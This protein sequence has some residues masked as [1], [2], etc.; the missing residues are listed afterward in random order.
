MKIKSKLLAG[1]TGVVLFIMICSTAAVYMLL[2]KQNHAVVQRNLEKTI[3]L[4]KDDLG[5]RQAKQIK[6]TSQLVTANKVGENIKFISDFAGQIDITRDGYVKTTGALAQLLS[7]SELWQA[8]VYDQKGMIIA[9]AQ[10]MT[11]NTLTVV[12][13]YGEGLLTFEHARLN[14]GDP[15]NEAKWQQSATSPLSVI[16]D[17]FAGDPV[18]ETQ[19]VRYIEAEG[20][21]CLQSTI[22]IHWSIKEKYTCTINPILMGIPALYA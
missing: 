15:L 9:S 2:N 14:A 22:P 5:K 18:A 8:A 16:A 10:T 6:D 4:I 17:R 3:N 21:V 19:R 20:G 11:D 13:T 1:A 7:A 12:Y